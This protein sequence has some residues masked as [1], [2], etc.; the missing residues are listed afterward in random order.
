MEEHFD[1]SELQR[2]IW[3]LEFWTG[4]YISSLHVAEF[5]WK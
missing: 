3:V 4:D 1:C 5:L 2:M